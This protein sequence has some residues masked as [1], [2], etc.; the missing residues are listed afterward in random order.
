M[1]RLD[2]YIVGLDVG[3]TKVCAVIGESM[4]DGVLEIVGVGLA[5]STGQRK[6][7]VVNIDE[8][9]ESI[10]AA[11]E[12]AE[13][14]AGISVDRAYVGVTGN[15]I[16]GFNSRGAI[17]VNGR[18]RELSDE[19]IE[20]VI[21]AARS[22]DL[23]PDREILH[24]LPREFVVDG[25]DSIVDPVGMSASRLEVNLHLVFGSISAVQNVVTSA[26]RGGIEVQAVVLQPLASNEAVLT[27]D[28]RQLG[29]ALVDIGGGTTDLVCFHGGSV[30]HTAVL[31]AGGDHFTN[32]VAV[33]LQTPL[34]DAEKIKTRFGC[35]IPELVDPDQTFEVPGIGG[36]SPRLM[37]RQQLC[38][39][40]R[41]RARE[42]LDLVKE[43]IVRSGF[44]DR[45]HAGIVL[46]GGG[47]LMEG[48][49]EAAEERHGLPVRLGLPIG[50]EGRVDVVA[51]PTYSTAVG[52]A[53]YG[54]R[55]RGRQPRFE[56]SGSAWHRR[57]GRR[58]QGWIGEFF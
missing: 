1:P 18:T 11:I 42:I 23:P 53:L 45:V 40:L 48:L 30:W 10:K 28:E 3:S 54:H 36:R 20:R 47:A 25:Q 16:R 49:I 37:P 34:T 35:V 22:L 9:V 41:L 38:D 4:D 27:D 55:N 50:I 26:N 15:H 44:V 8:T 19:D 21:E 13:L 31:P 39:I 5:S 14:M 12:E 7:V 43:E 52:L 24:L 57:F 17:N 29:T 33:G 58:L 32:D 56:R 46:T 51:S 2:R 6:G